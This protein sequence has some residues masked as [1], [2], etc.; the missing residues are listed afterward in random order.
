MAYTTCNRTFDAVADVK[1]SGLGDLTTD[2][3][4]FYGGRPSESLHR[5]IKQVLQ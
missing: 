5:T 4:L 3:N 1:S 2:V